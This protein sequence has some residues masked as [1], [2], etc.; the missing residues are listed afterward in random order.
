MRSKITENSSLKAIGARRPEIDEF[1]QAHASVPS[2]IKWQLLIVLSETAVSVSVHCTPL[3]N[4]KRD[5]E[6]VTPRGDK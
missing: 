4:R 1:Y 2:A 6:S 3:I 5:R